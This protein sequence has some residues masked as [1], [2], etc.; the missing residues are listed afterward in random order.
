MKIDITQGVRRVLQKSER[1]RKHETDL[2]FSEPFAVTTLG[3]LLAL[4]DEDEC[5]AAAWLDE[6]GMNRLLVANTLIFET[7]DLTSEENG[8]KSKNIET[9]NKFPTRIRFFLDGDEVPVGR[10]EPEFVSGVF[11]ATQHLREILPQV[12]F[13]TEHLLYALSL[14]E[15]EIGTFLRDHDVTPERLFGKICRQEGIDLEEPEVISV[16]WDDISANDLPMEMPQ[17]VTNIL[18]TGMPN[19]PA[20]VY[21]ILDASAN[22][23]V[24]AVRVLEDYVRFGLDN[25]EMVKMTK[26]MRHELASALQELPQHERLAARSTATDVGTNIE[27]TNEY[28]RTSLADVLGAN[29]SRFQ[30]SLR[31]LEEY[32]KIV[33][34]Q[35]ARTAERLRY[36]SY[37]LQKVVRVPYTTGST[38]CDVQQRLLQSCLYVLIDCRKPE[39]EFVALV[40]AV[41]QGGAD[42]IQLRDKQADDRLLLQ[43]AGSLRE[44]TTG[45]QT[46]MIVNDR[47]DLA[48]LSRADGVHVGQEEFAPSDVR[49]LVGAGM[50]IGVSTHSI[51]QARQALLDGADYLGA[52]PVFPSLTKT[53]DAFPGTDFLRQIA[54]EISLP[55]FAIG[56]INPDNLPHVIEAGLRRVAV[57]SAVTESQDPAAMCRLVKEIL[58]THP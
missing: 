45:T 15:D 36:Q 22:R 39:T 43:R 33:A 57:Q 25:A 10:L 9:D 51:E 54:A 38:T 16:A 29:F 32:G 1:Y 34:P 58:A 28:R 47:P 52:G 17:S 4:L 11:Q 27:G 40:Q 50:L 55:V 30:E 31:S 12:V 48:L 37:T 53:F 35:L 6:C 5:R 56:G 21:R 44:L 24:E 8:E 3:V 13:A 26:Q 23:A 14:A 41:I 19:D 7:L 42:V 20:T 18:L 46:L 49:Q 2:H